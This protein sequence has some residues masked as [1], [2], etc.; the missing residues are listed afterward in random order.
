MSLQPVAIAEDKQGGLFVVIDDQDAA[1]ALLIPCS[2]D[3]RRVIDR[4]EL[5][6]GDYTLHVALPPREADA[7][8]RTPEERHG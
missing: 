4:E 8:P 7:N 6:G 2:F 1:E 3:H 5:H